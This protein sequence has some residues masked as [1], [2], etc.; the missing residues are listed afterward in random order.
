MKIAFIT[1]DGQVKY[2]AANGFDEIQDLLPFL[3]SK[4]L[5]IQAEIWDD[6]AVDWSQYEVALLRMPWDYTEKL[7]AFRNWLDK[8]ENLGIGLLNDYETVRWNIDKR[9][10][11]EIAAAGFDVI[12]SV[13]LDENWNGT[14]GSLFEALQSDQLILKPCVSAGSRNTIRLTKSDLEQDENQP[15]ALPTSESYIAQPFMPE[16]NDGEW[17]FTFFNG[18]HSHTVLKKPQQGD[19][20]VQQFFGGT[21]ELVHPDQARIDK[22]ASYLAAFAPRALYARVDGVMVDGNFMLMEL[23]L[24]EPFLY[25]AYDPSSA[26]RYFEAIT[27]QLARLADFTGS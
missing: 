10:L 2:S 20:R 25:L 16:I 13:F 24:I 11:G 21:I 12:P 1:Y 19:F 15:V 18:Q 17:S 4:G 26:E 23:E 22:A 14:A 3:Q 27:A 7:P 9:Y 8:I 6:P 5:D